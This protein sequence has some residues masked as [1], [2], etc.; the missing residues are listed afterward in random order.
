MPNLFLAGDWTDTGVPA[1]IESAVRSGFAA[2]RC[3]TEFVDPGVEA[4]VFTF[5]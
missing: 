4:F 3:L 5:G 2:A 1:S